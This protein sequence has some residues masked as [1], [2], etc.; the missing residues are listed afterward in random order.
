MQNIYKQLP[1]KLTSRE[2]NKPL[3]TNQDPNLITM[4][5]TKIQEKQKSYIIPFELFEK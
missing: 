5:T 2:R 3:K 4:T 1:P